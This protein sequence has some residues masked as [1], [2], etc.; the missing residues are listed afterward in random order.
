MAIADTVIPSIEV[1]SDLSLKSLS[2]SASE[3]TTAIEAVKGRL[4]PEASVDLSRQY[5]RE[6]A[7]SL[8]AFRALLQRTLADFLPEEA[9][10]GIRIILSALE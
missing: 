5:F 2:L 10:K 1:S 7:S 9:R 6:S 3:Y 4:L 8:P